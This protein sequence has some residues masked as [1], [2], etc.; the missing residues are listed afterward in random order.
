MARVLSGKCLSEVWELLWEGWTLRPGACEPG[1][2]PRPWIPVGPSDLRFNPW[3][4]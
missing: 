1:S 4:Q 3:L 2:A